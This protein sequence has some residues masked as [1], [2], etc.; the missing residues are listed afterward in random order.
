MKWDSAEDMEAVLSYA[1]A[2][3]HDGDIFV[4]RIRGDVPQK[5]LRAFRRAI[6]A[7][8]EEM[9]WKERGILPLVVQ[10]DVEMF[11]VKGPIRVEP[12]SFQIQR[13][14]NHAFSNLTALGLDASNDSNVGK[15]TRAIVEAIGEEFAAGFGESRD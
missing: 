8:A 9:G 1:R 2:E 11:K 4:V 5:Q 6:N 3:V 7:S 13:V 10:G 12:K 15:I 14:V